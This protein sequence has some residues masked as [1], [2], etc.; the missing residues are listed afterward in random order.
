MAKCPY[1]GKEVSKDEM[2]CWHCEN[3]LS[4]LKNKLEKPESEEDHDH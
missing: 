3:D 4:E 1:C 2:F